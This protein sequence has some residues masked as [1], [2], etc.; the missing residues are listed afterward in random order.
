[1]VL[2]NLHEPGVVDALIARVEK[3][4]ITP[5]RKSALLET[6]CRL[7][8]R[9]AD[10]DGSWWSTRPDTT[11]PY[12]KTATWDQTEKISAC[13]HRCLAKSEPS[14]TALLEGLFQKY[15]IQPPKPAVV[16][17]TPN[18]PESGSAPVP[19]SLTPATN[20]VA[21]LPYE[22]LVKLT[23]ASV[24]A[25][26]HGDKLFETIGCV[27]CHTVS[28]N[29]PPKGPF[30][31]DLASRYSK[32]EIIESIVRPNA[33]I[34]QGFETATVETKDGD[35]YDG[36][37]VRESGDEL[38]LRNLNGAVV[39]PKSKIATRGLRKL[40]IMPEGLVNGLTPEDLSSLVAYLQSLKSK[41]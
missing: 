21:A 22:D 2:G 24:G 3:P 17:F 23:S 13:L 20:T 37:I 19:V 33:K 12:Y 26:T 1:M 28:T 41:I 9:E 16:K 30:L 15:K 5:A 38:E 7:Y 14:E 11:G 29:E 8:F 31:G 35:S 6:L 34:A 18:N 10:W 32:A 27:K 25:A 39:I 36:F 40:S 4:T